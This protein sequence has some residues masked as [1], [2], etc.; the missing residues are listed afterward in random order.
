VRKLKVVWLQQLSIVDSMENICNAFNVLKDYL[1]IL[2]DSKTT[3]CT[4][5]DMKMIFLELIFHFII[6]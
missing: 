4:L 2:I 6:L 5:V 3:I 1:Y